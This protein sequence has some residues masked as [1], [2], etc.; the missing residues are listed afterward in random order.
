MKEK[1][2]IDVRHEI[3]QVLL[4]WRPEMNAENVVSAIMHALEDYSIT[5]EGSG[6]SGLRACLFALKEKSDNRIRS[7]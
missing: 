7:I 4:E 2:A 5:I 3:S 6:E 1:E